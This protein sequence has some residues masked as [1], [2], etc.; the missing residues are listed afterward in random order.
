MRFYAPAFLRH[1]YPS[2]IWSF[3]GEQKSVFLT[4]DDGPRPEVTPWVLDQLD[5]F[6]AKATF[7]CLGKNVEMFPD[8]FDDIKLR[9]HSVGNHSYSHIKGWGMDTGAYIQDVDF[10]NDLIHSN[11]YR[12][13]Y[14][15]IGPNQARMLSERYNIIMWDILSRD[16][17]KHLS[18]KKCA[19]NVIKHTRPGSIIVFH[20]SIKSARNLW[21]TLPLV[22]KH[23]Q[24][25]D[26]QC[27]PIEL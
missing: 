27:N 7:F 10:A 9:G 1:I 8:L 19:R 17:S 22:L 14:G 21:T 15:R 20:D 25:Q 26:W 6:N 3:E 5:K 24:S 13:P 23:F 18:G 16:Y 12:P 2:F 11:L 4:F